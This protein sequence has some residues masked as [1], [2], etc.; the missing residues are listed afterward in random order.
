MKRDFEYYRNFEYYRKFIRIE[1]IVVTVA[2]ITLVVAIV[3]A[4]VHAL[5]GE[6]GKA[7]FLAVF[8]TILALVLRWDPPLFNIELRSGD[9]DHPGR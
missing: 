2:R 8:A 5:L 3:G 9:D 1:R 4:L 7:I 6:A